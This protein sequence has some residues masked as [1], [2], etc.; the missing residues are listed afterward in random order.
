M[1]WSA[2]RPHGL[3]GHIVDRS[4]KGYTLFTPL[5]G[6]STYL[7][8]M[9]GL[10]VHRWHFPDLLMGYGRLLENGNL[11]LIANL[12]GEADGDRYIAE[13]PDAPVEKR[14]RSLGGN[15]SLAREVNWEGETVWEYEN[16]AIHHDFK[17]LPNGNT[18]FPHWIELDPETERNVRGGR[19][20][21]KRNKPP[22]L[23]DEVIEVAPDGKTVRS[24][25]VSSL[26]DPRR[27]SICPLERRIEWTHMN[28]IDVDEQG[29]ILFSCRNVSV[30]GI[31]GTEGELE[32]TIATPEIAHQ[33][34]ATWLPNGR[35]SSSTS[36]PTAVKYSRATVALAYG[37]MSSSRQ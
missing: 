28:S 18:V 7:I 19:R 31:I 15:A 27:H 17:R 34:N 25:S 33:H 35:V 26:L 11:L 16:P 13:D 1:G 12:Q 32:W 2:F 23:G 37:T 21:R 4:Y 22:M 20:D 14:L 10:I 30:V 8:D 3:T 6:D 5:R 36:A 9:D 24:V 29:R